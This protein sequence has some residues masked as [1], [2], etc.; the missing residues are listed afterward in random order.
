MPLLERMTHDVPER[1]EFFLSALR[2]FASRTCYANIGAP[3]SASRSIRDSCRYAS[4]HLT[5]PPAPPLF[6]TRV[7]TQPGT[8]SLAGQTAPSASCTSCHSCLPLEA[9][10]MASWR[11]MISGRHSAPGGGHAAGVCVRGSLGAN[12]QECSC[13]QLLLCALSGST[14]RLSPSARMVMRTCPLTRR[15]CQKRQGC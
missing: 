5:P 10:P 12:P 11:R 14:P 1:G 13:A 8:T 7:R 9:R 6:T 3:R 2:A 15:Q 4:A